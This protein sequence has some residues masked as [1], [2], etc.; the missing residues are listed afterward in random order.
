M[1]VGMPTLLLS[2][3]AV[4]SMSNQS[5]AS[6]LLL[7]I[8]TIIV[9]I[10]YT[11][12]VRYINSALQTLLCVT[13]RVS[14]GDLSMEELPIESKNEIGQLA[15]GVNSMVN[16]L[17]NMIQQVAASAEQVAAASEQ[18]A[19]LTEQ[20]RESSGQIASVIEAVAQ[21][22]ETQAIGSMSTTTSMGEMSLGIQRIVYTSS[23]V[24]EASYETAERAEQG[25]EY[26]QKAIDQMSS[27]SSAAD[28]SASKVAILDE[29]SREIG[30]IIEVITEIASATQLLSLNASIEAARAGDHGRGFAV[31]ANEV[32][33]LATQSEK[34]AQKIADLIHEIQNHTNQTAEAMDDVTREVEAG[35]VMVDDAGAAFQRILTSA[36]IVDDQIQEISAASAEMA[37][38]SSQVASAFA[39]MSDIAYQTSNHSKECNDTFHIQLAAI[40]DMASSS[41]ELSQLAHE[42]Q[43]VLR[44]F[45]I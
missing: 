15:I 40:Q 33:K 23:L 45:R 1:F 4:T 17:R 3:V 2:I 14:E 7:C 21:G 11:L 18:M 16:N 31:V 35:M 27:I 41:E 10:G 13:K 32:R 22:A 19:A 30:Q 29:R 44:N 8:P 5:D 24:S 43:Q 6:I 26:I 20:A 39:T 34:S 36:Q 9:A 37:S 12:F 38:G 25:N 28:K 42:M